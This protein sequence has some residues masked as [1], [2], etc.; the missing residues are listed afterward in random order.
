MQGNGDQQRKQQPKF[1]E[2]AVQMYLGNSHI[3]ILYMG[4]SDDRMFRSHM[5]PTDFTD[6][7]SC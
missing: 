5:N 3:D 4:M 7:I 1:Q 2:T 6:N